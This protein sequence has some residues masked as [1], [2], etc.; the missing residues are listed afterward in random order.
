MAKTGTG[1]GAGAAG[2]A[3]WIGEGITHCPLTTSDDLV[4]AFD[5]RCQFRLT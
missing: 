4:C 3:G 5:S 1:A 2:G